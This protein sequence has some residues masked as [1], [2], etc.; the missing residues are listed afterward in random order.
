MGSNPTAL[1]NVAG[2][3]TVT[4]VKQYPSI[5]NSGGQSF[6]D[7]GLVH[8][9]DKLD[10][11]NLRVEWTKK[12]GFFKFGSRTQLIDETSLQFEDAPQLMIEQGELVL[13]RLKKKPQKL[14]IFGEYYGPNSFAGVH[15]PADEKR[16]TVF[17]VCVDNRGWMDPKDFV[18]QFEG[19]VDTPHY[20]GPLSWSRGF[21]QRVREGMYD[22]EIT[23]EGVVGKT[24]LGPRLKMGKA[25]SQKWIDK[26]KALYP[27]AAGDK[28]INS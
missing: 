11:S 16:F 23:F 24:L 25:K 3:C 10:G 7:L 5:P 22:T 8:V 19:V 15:F 18:K 6:E 14:V 4:Y 2:C 1:T 21:I 17:D 13:S 20:L 27:G 9:F 26:V 28:I 12:R